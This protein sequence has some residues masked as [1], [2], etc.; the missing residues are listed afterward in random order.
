[1]QRVDNLT[2]MLQAAT[3]I[4][5]R[6]LVHCGLNSHGCADAALSLIGLHCKTVGHIQL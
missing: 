1:M 3:H 2:S 5:Y 6:K 4:L